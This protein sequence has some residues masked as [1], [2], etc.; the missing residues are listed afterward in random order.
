MKSHP[1]RLSKAYGVYVDWTVEDPPRAF[2]VG[3]GQQARVK[4]VKRNVH[5]TRISEKHGIRREL[6]LE[7]DDPTE[8]AARE[9]ELIASLKTY[10]HAADYVFGANHTAG[11]EGAPGRKYKPTSEALKRQSEAQRGKKR[12]QQSP[13]HRAAISASLTGKSRLIHDAAAFREKCSETQRRR[14]QDPELR[15]RTGDALRG[16]SSTNRGRKYTDEQRAARSRQLKE[17]WARKRRTDDT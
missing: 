3:K 7:T 2:Y 10:V 5:H 4:S 12:G 15:K 1:I 17:Y 14:M 16:K 13:D 6:V 9:V 11:D 8:A